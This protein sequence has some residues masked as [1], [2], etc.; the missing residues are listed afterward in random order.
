MEML[1][2][3]ESSTFPFDIRDSIKRWAEAMSLSGKISVIGSLI[4]PS[5]YISNRRS[6]MP[7]R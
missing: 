5:P 2:Y 4:A 1:N 3:V 7:C 6:T